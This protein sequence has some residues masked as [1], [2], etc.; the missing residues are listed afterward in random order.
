M[1]KI[2]I[3]ISKGGTGK[4][5]TAVN[6]AAGLAALDYAVL[7]ID[8]DTQGQCAVALGVKPKIGLA[9]LLLENAT[10][11]DII[12]PARDHLQLLAGGPDITRARRHIDAEPF[13]LE[14]YLSKKLL[15]IEGKY[16]FV[17]IDT[18]PG[19]D[20]LTINVLFYVSEVIAPVNMESLTINS[21]SD[22]RARVDHL[23]ESGAP[24]RLRHVLP[25]FL[26]GRVKKTDEIY[27][28]LQKNFGPALCEPIRYNSRLSEAP[29]FGESIF[30]Y[31]GKSAGAADYSELIKRILDYGQ[32]KTA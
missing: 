12:T 9:D 18:G 6:L 11:P 7:L 32:K 14:R 29:T 1:R 28:H 23:A 2:G 31:D 21:L 13:Q 22:F 8:T 17:V 15:P 26:D 16:D 20:S 5:T 27:Q 19:W 24:A 25:T 4:T 30:E 10:F 3:T